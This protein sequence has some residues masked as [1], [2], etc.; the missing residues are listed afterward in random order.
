[1]TYLTKQ[2]LK[3]ILDPSLTPHDPQEYLHAAM[4]WHFG[5]ETGSPFWLRRA[6]TLNFDPLT[7]ITSYE[8]LSLFPNVVD[9]LRNVPVEDLIPLGYGPNP[10]QPRVF[11]SGGT[12]GSPKRVI[13]MPDCLEGAVQRMV[14]GPRFAGREPANVLLMMPSGPHMVGCMYDYVAK[15]QNVIKFCIDMDPRWVKK[16]VD[17]G[18]ADQAKVYV[19]HLL[20]QAEQVLSSQS[21]GLLVTTPPLLWA[22]ARRT[23]LAQLINDKIEL[24]YWGGTHMKIDERFELQHKHFPKVSFLSGYSSIMIL[25]DGAIER[26][27]LTADQDIIYDPHSPAATFRVINPET[28]DPVDYGKRGQVVMTHIS[29]GMFVPNNLER[30]TAI[31]V[32]GLPGQIGDSVSAP[33]PVDTFRGKVVTEGIY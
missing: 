2:Q 18:L 23:S 30:D 8:D 25:G 31:R 10:A 15:V 6:N 5:S 4:A 1:M 33:E 3:A 21:A 19:E 24:I 11:E 14:Q 29:K 20:D 32:P 12:T 28:G 16:L 22:C 13:L 9:E 27:G 17:R 7:D 26:A